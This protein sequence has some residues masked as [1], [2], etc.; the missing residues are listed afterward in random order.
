MTTILII[1]AIWLVASLPASIIVGK[2]IH[3]GMSE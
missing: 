1:L 3:W 2:A